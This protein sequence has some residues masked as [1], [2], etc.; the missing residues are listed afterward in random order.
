MNVEPLDYNT[1][2]WV[3]EAIFK[4]VRRHHNVKCFNCGRIG[5]L[6]RDCIPGIPKIMSPLRMMKIESLHLL[7]YVEDTAKADIG[8]MKVDQQKT[9]NSTQYHWKTPWGVTRR[10]KGQTLSG[11]SQSL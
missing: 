5:H 6:R 10:P 7:D 4:G 9:R 2:T 1:E 8:P 3:G 11:R